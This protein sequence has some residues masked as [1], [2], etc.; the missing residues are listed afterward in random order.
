MNS[1]KSVCSRAK[2][3]PVGLDQFEQDVDA[4]RDYLAEQAKRT[5]VSAD[6]LAARI[7]GRRRD[8]RPLPDES[9]LNAFTYDDDPRGRR[10]R[11]ARDCCSIPI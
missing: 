5:G 11:A 10:R 7:I 9:T 2:G 8:G 3:V 4:F 6:E 1:L